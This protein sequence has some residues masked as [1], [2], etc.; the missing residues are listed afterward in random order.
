MRQIPNSEYDR[1]MKLEAAVRRVVTQRADDLCWRDVYTELAELVGVEFC[2]ALMADPEQ[3]N[4][5]C[6]R[7][8]ESLRNGGQ[9]I[10]VY[11]EKVN[12][13][14]GEKTTAIPKSHARGTQAAR[15]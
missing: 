3:F 5:N 6:R 11:G 15:R 1:L 10:P 13:S 7:F 14:H 2:P 9:Y 4:A 12:E 8:D